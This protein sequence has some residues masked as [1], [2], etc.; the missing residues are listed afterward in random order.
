MPPTEN[1]AIAAGKPAA[2]SQRMSAER[3][4]HRADKTTAAYFEHGQAPR[5]DTDLVVTQALRKQYPEL[6]LVVVADNHMSGVEFLSFAAAGNGSF[7]RVEDDSSLPSSLE[8]TF[9][10]PPSRRMD[11]QKGFTANYILF[12]KFLYKWNDEEFLLYIADGRDGQSGFPQYKNS[13]VLGTNEIKINELVLAAGAWAGELHNELWVFDQGWWFKDPSLWQSAQGASW[14]D[15]ILDE[16]MKK[17]LIDDHNSFFDSKSTYKN[18]GV[19]WK[20]GII[21]HGPPGNGKTISVRATMHM[22]LDRDPSIPTMYVRSIDSWMGPQ[23][24]ISLIFAKAREFAPCYIVLED[25]DTLITP[26]VRSYFLNEV[27][28]LKQNDGIFIIATTNH[29]E[30]LDP[31]IAKRPSRFDR[32]YYFPDPNVDQREA[33]CYFWQKKLKSNKD[34]DFPDQLCRAI[35]EITD[36]FS[37]AYIQEAFV[38]TLLAIARRT[39]GKRASGGSGD[40]WVLVSDDEGPGSDGS[41]GGEDDLDK[42]ELFVEMKRQVKILREGIED[43]KDM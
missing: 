27:D 14:D 12:G 16:D 18:L 35:A 15:V 33:Y 36:G 25:I 29:L 21:Y 39:K 22:L 32:K 8:W 31:G 10:Q 24:C 19:P 17:S 28:G 1:P 20:R 41:E 5:T 11:G 13:Y 37:F 34:V 7:T 2:A 26:Y 9:Y 40:A 23:A 43:E 4:G 30:D 3:S 38:A 42:F 6:K